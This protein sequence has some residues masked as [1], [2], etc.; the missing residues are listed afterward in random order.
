MSEIQQ[1][2]DTLVAAHHR[3]PEEGAEA[4]G[5]LYADVV[6]VTHNPP[7]PTDGRVSG[8][9]LRVARREKMPLLRAAATN[10]HTTAQAQARGDLIRF[11]W[12]YRGVLDDGTLMAAVQRCELTVRD[13][14]IVAI[15]N[16]HDPESARL[17]MRLLAPALQAH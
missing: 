1:L 5:A 10:F 12:T 11:S 3:S 17:L 9:A 8:E 15:V 14:R 6:Q 13:G 2:A 16:H 4:L 7:A